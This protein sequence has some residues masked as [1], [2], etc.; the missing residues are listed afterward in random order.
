MDD[1]ENL[2]KMKF[3][4]E[5]CADIIGEIIELM[6]KLEKEENEEKMEQI[7]NEIEEKTGMYVVQMLKLNSFL[8][9]TNE[10]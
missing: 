7:T 9:K 1:I 2:K 4:Y 6:D 5:K 3:F 10:Q 8:K